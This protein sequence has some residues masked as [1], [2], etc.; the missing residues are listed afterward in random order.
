MVSTDSSESGFAG[1]DFAGFPGCAGACT[2]GVCAVGVDGPEAGVDGVGVAAGGAAGVE[3][4]GT[5][6]PTREP[7]SIGKAIR[8]RKMR[9]FIRTVG[10]EVISSL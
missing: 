1:S 3:A 6:W 7:A 4:G 9:D 8:S 10:S 2:A 5:V